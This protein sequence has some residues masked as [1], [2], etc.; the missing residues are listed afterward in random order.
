MIRHCAVPPSKLSVQN[1]R[2]VKALNLAGTEYLSQAMIDAHSEPVE[3]EARVIPPPDMRFYHQNIRKP[4]PNGTWTG[5]QYLL[6]ASCAKW[7]AIV[8]FYERDSRND[9]S[10]DTWK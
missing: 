1:T 7:A 2:V 5:A 10:L 8:F 6:P 3:V 4:M 9:L